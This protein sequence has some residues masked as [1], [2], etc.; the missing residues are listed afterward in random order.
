[1]KNGILLLLFVLVNNVI[2]SQTCKI[3][4]YVQ[5]IQSGE[6]LIGAS[7]YSD[8]QN[9][10]ITNGFGYFYL[11]LK[12]ANSLFHVSY[13]GYHTKSISFNCAK[14]SI[15]IVELQPTV[16]EIQEVV[17]TS[18]KENRI[19]KTQTDY[20]NIPL[21]KIKS[22]PSL[23]GEQ[24]LIKSLTYLPGIQFATE[25]TANISIRGGAPE[26]NLVLIDDVPVYNSNHLFGVF[27]IYNTDALKN[28][29]LL[30]G[31]FPARYGGRVSS[32]LDL[33]MKEGDLNNFHGN[34]SLG[35]ISSKFMLEGPIIKQKLSFLVTG[36]RTFLDLLSAPFSNLLW[37]EQGEERQFSYFFYDFTGKINYI[38]NNHNRL[39]FSYYSGKDPLSIRVYN[40]SSTDTTYNSDE[41]KWKM[42]YGNKI[43]SFRWNHVF[44]NGIFLNTTFI[45]SNYNFENTEFYKGIATL[46]DSTFT[47]SYN[48]GLSSGL[49]DFGGKIDFDINIIQSHKIKLGTEAIQHTF[50]PGVEIFYLND[51]NTNLNLDSIKTQEKYLARE[52]SV[53]IEDDWNIT[54]KLGVNVGYRFNLYSL[55]GK[56]YLSNEPRFT[57]RYLITPLVSIKASYSKISQN[58]HLLSNTGISLPTDL[59]VT[60]TKKIKPIQSEQFSVGLNVL[61][62]SKA[63]QITIEAYSKSLRNVI[64]YKE[65]A[66]FI[67]TTTNWENKVESGIGRSNGI[68]FLIEK[69]EGK[70]QGWLSYTLSKAT[71]QFDNISFGKEFPYKYDRR[72]NLSITW[73]YKI[74]ENKQININWI[75]ATGNPVTFAFENFE[76]N[77]YQFDELFNSALPGGDKGN[78]TNRNNYRLPSY[79]RLDVGFSLT[80][81]KNW[82]IAEWNIGVYNLYNRHNALFLF[83][84]DSK[85]YKFSL[86]PIIPSVSYSIKF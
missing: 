40:S 27:S 3:H 79:H 77:M 16:N 46:K 32:V 73:I 69:N 6:R 22:I 45:Y 53:Y 72:H 5:D 23:L 63:Y 30:K 11:Q 75:F 71:R 20:I 49:T 35:I 15:I 28:A 12:N 74:G 82:G 52:L 44:E 21:L 60:S 84:Q 86:L 10:T 13:I 50:S 51:L 54:N 58:V 85:L 56:H 39:Y 67:D 57:A 41:N 33:R 65:G 76:T 55:S 38:L 42:Q 48:L 59:W 64:E 31:G 2:L 78:Y 29:T 4:G 14:D 1:M 83:E 7:V 26:Q 62:K 70:L 43:A 19:E 68:E 9:G 17:I 61:T 24:D 66:S 80:K 81:N 18:E 47:E 34:A 36:R 8:N 25:G 37:E